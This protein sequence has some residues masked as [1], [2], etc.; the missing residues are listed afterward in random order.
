MSA[1]IKIT[2]TNRA[3]T[4]AGNNNQFVSPL[5]GDG[6]SI[7]YNLDFWMT[8]NILFWKI[9]PSYRRGEGGL[10]HYRFILTYLGEHVILSIK[11]P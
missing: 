6:A 10:S 8:P 7:F 4:L 1:K 9:I 5:V 3:L 11:S 2:L